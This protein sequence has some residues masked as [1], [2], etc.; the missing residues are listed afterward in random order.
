MSNTLR[1]EQQIEL[2]GL[3]DERATLIKNVTRMQARLHAI[4]I[5]TKA[6]RDPVATSVADPRRCPGCPWLRYFGT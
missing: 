3:L 2:Q 4:N 6:L 1:Q 5:R